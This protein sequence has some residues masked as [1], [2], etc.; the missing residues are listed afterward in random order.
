MTDVFKHTKSTD[1]VLLVY[2]AEGR[3]LKRSYSI[4]LIFNLKLARRTAPLMQFVLL[5]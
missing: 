1:F 2:I 3:D 5:N 4:N